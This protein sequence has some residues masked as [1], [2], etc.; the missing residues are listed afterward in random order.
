MN[1]PVG[2]SI[3]SER[4]YRECARRSC[5]LRGLKLLAPEVIHSVGHVLS[6]SP[7]QGKA[8]MS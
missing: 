6:E 2:V 4:R 5:Q 8:A 1:L 7:I 3:G